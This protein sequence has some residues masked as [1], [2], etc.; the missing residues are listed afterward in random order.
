MSA[1]RGNVLVRASTTSFTLPASDAFES[2][3]IDATV[4][5]DEALGACVDS[6]FV[7]VMTVFSVVLFMT[8]VILI[9]DPGYI[10]TV[11][12]SIAKNLLSPLI[13]TPA[14]CV[15]D[16]LPSVATR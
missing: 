7:T 3:G 6:H 4:G 13:S 11:L 10:V 16:I 8:S 2:I 1:V 5:A 12:P 14:V 15:N 9:L